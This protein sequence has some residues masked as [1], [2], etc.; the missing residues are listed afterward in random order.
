M[1]LL[2]AE[3]EQGRANLHEPLF[4]G[5]HV[6]GSADVPSSERQVRER[7]RAR[8]LR[9]CLRARRSMIDLSFNETAVLAESAVEVA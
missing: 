3:V 7:V 9:A 2:S 6:E 4:R 8:A 1:D 5:L